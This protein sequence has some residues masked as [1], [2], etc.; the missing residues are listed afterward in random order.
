MRRF[1]WRIERTDKVQACNPGHAC[2]AIELSNC[3]IK[4]LGYFTRRL[5]LRDDGM[6]L[7]VY[8]PERQ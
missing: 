8:G 1:S 3:D 4:L 5:V 7:A 2:C 6:A